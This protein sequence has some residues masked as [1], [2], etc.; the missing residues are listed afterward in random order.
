MSDHL[1]ELSVN[2]FILFITKRDDAITAAQKISFNIF[3]ISIVFPLFVSGADLEP[4]Y[5]A[6]GYSLPTDTELFQSSCFS[7]HLGKPS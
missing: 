7:A 5:S 4:I 6:S 3:I 1:S 2:Y